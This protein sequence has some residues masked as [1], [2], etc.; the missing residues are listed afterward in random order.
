MGWRSEETIPTGRFIRDFLLEHGE[1]YPYGIWKALREERKKAG[2]LKICTYQSF[3]INYISNLKKLRL[4]E[5]VRR[6]ESGGWWQKGKGILK[7]RIY[8]R[9]VPGM[10][11]KDDI[12]K[13]PQKAIK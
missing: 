13:A 5:E 6:E 9:V 1:G 8:Y 2:D 12:W 11:D 7:D 10:E 3:V 4:I